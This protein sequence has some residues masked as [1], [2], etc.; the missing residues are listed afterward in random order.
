L[1]DVCSTFI[2]R[3]WPAKGRK[4]LEKDFILSADGGKKL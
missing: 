4:R 2:E 1:I 3:R